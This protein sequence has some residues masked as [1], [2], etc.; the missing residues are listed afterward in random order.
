MKGGELKKVALL[1][2]LLLRVLSD[3][4]PKAWH[5]VAVAAVSVLEDPVLLI[6]VMM[7]PA[8]QAL[9]LEMTQHWVVSKL[10]AQTEAQ[11]ATKVLAKW[12]W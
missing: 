8:M 12:R 10:G 11:H 2:Y 9:A 6:P 7:S 3:V 4:T 5:L 1:G